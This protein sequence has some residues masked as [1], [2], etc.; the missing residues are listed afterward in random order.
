MSTV[1]AELVI[2]QRTDNVHAN[3]YV[4]AA[5]QLGLTAEVIDREK[6][7]FRISSETK[8]L[9]NHGGALG[10]NNPVSRAIANNKITTIRLLS[11][12][13]VPVPTSEVF[14]VDDDLRHVLTSAK[15]RFPLVVKPVCGQC[16]EGVVA[17]I[18]NESELEAAL[19]ALRALQRETFILENHVEGEDFRILVC[20]GEI[21]DVLK[22]VPANVI[23]DG[24]STLEK[25]IPLR[26][27]ER[28]AY[29]HTMST[30][31]VDT[32]ILDF[33]EQRGLALGHVP[34]RGQKILLR[35]ICNFS[36]GG[37]VSSVPVSELNPEL[38]D[39]FKAVQR[40]IGL[41]FCGVDYITPNITKSFRDVASCVNEV[42][43]RP[44]IQ[45]HC[46]A[47]P[48]GISLDP[49]LKVLETAFRERKGAGGLTARYDGDS[50]AHG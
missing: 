6:G 39:L 3:L 49:A 15:A 20:R 11:R 30:I 8:S 21:I 38:V 1:G 19:A 7:V 10:M 35:R 24:R 37:E 40:R 22:R 13:G 42:N 18:K 14:H 16:G 28:L 45:I 25:L 5:E 4:Q 31:D 12:F 2:R 46:F 48:E 41:A 23:G 29:H 9:V 33:L 26:N 47:R 27:R 36:K 43:P 50:S 34:A 44:G 17:N 32:D